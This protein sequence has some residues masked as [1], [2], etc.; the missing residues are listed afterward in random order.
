M[1]SEQTNANVGGVAG[2][3]KA[4]VTDL[5]IGTPAQL[6]LAAA[7]LRALAGESSGK[8]ACMQ[9]GGLEALVELIISSDADGTGVGDAAGAIANLSTLQSGRRLIGITKVILEGILQTRLL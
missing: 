8:V 4:Y 7:S 1:T 9:G 3:V 5:Q 6:A 2:Q